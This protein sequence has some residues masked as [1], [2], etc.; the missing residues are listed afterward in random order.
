MRRLALVAGL[1][2]AASPAAASAIAPG[3]TVRAGQ[4]SLGALAQPDTSAPWA[5]VVLAWSREV[6]GAW[7]NDS[8]RR[9]L[10]ALARE[11]QAL[12]QG[13]SAETMRDS[14]FIRRLRA[15]D[16]ANAARMRAII[17]RHGWPGKRMV[18]VRGAEAAF[19]L[20]QHSPELI[21]TGLALMQRAAPGEVS[22][23]ELAMLTDRE[24]T[25]RGRPQLFGSQLSHRDGIASFFPIEDAEHVEERRA[26][27][28]L[29][30][31]RAYACQLATL[32]RAPVVLPEGIGR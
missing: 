10:L 13:I 5:R 4:C 16:S 29:P 7:T 31:L 2:L 15:T 32:Y 26:R 3:D 27:A 20:V 19:L 11:D 24:R 1:A 18:G 23:V 17:T 25:G 12:R 14:A 30:P 28:G 22:P 21:P 8:L 9:E 6:P